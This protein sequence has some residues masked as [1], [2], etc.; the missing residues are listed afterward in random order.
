MLE[1][2]GWSSSRLL[3]AVRPDHDAV[4]SATQAGFRFR[5]RMGLSRLER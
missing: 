3:V 2:P 5:I 1:S 4:K